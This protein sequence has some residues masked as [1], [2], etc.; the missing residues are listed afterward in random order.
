MYLL[1]LK[2]DIN[3]ILEKEDLKSSRGAG[4]EDNVRHTICIP[5]VTKEG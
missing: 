2:T 5:K 4:M 3:K 1:K